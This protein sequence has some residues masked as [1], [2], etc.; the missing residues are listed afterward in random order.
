MSDFNYLCKTK[1]PQRVFFVQPNILYIM[2]KTYYF[3][4]S[5]DTETGAKLAALLVRIN[6]ADRAADA[7]ASEMGATEY[8]PATEAD[9]GGIAGFV[10]PKNK[11]I[12]KDNWTGVQ[13]GDS[14]DD[15]AYTPNVTTH[16]IAVPTDEAARYEGKAVVSRAEYD[17]NQVSHLFSREEAAAMAGVT[18]TTPPLDRLGQ[19]YGI[20][21]KV[22]NMI[23]MGAPAHIL[24]KGFDSEVVNAFTHSQQE[25]KAIVDVMANVKFRTVMTIKG[26]DRARDVF[27]RML[28]LP[29][30]PHGTLNG[31]LGIDDNQFRAGIMLVDDTIYITSHKPCPTLTA[32]TEAEWQAAGEIRRAKNMKPTANC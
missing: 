4:T 23:S 6:E 3:K 9:Y 26:S 15:M 28:A 25:D 14:P 31:L 11:L 2:N 18:L 22:V 13:V 24:L 1:R 16:T 30:V 21:R 7:L 20:E 27:L 10:F 12:V 17:F 32:I 5:T 19:R 8:F 29:V